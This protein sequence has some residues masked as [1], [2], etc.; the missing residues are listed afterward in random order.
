MV[1]YI[2]ISGLVAEDAKKGGL[3]WKG[4]DDKSLEDTVSFVEAKE[5]TCGALS[6]GPTNA[7]ISFYK[8]EGKA[9]GKILCKLCKVNIE[10]T[11]CLPCWKKSNPKKD[12]TKQP[13]EKDD[14]QLMRQV[15][16]FSLVESAQ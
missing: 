15:L 6:R 5:M 2:V 14:K 3:G 1:K 12:K 9:A 7:G 8:K 10:C 16:L 11:L 13:K 4:L